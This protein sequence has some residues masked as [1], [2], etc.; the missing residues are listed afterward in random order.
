MK[1]KVKKIPKYNGGGTISPDVLDKASGLSG[2]RGSY[3]GYTD[4]VGAGLEGGMNLLNMAFSEQDVNVGTA[5]QGGMQGFSTGMQFGGPLGGVIGA[6]VG[7]LAGTAGRTNQVDTQSNSLDINQI[8][9]EGSGWLQGFGMSD[10]EMDVLANQVQRSNMAKLQ[11]ENLKANYYSNPNVVQNPN[12]LA[13]EGGVVPGEH[14]ASR[15]EVEVAADGT[16]AVKYGWDPK[17]KDTYHVYANPDGSS[18]EGN[19]VFTEEGVRR[20][21][22]EKYSDA[23]EKII[24][25]TKEGSKLRQISLRKLANEMEVQ[26]MCKQIKKM[27]NGVP[28]HEGGTDGKRFDF[29]NSFL[30]R[31]SDGKF[32]MQDINGNRQDVPEMMLPYIQGDEHGYW[33]GHMTGV[34]PS[35]GKWNGSM[36]FAKQMLNLKNVQKLK[37]IATRVFGRNAK[38]VK[39]ASVKPTS[40][41]SKPLEDSAKKL[42]EA[43]EETRIAQEQNRA[44]MS[45][46]WL[47]GRTPQNNL[48]N[49]TIGRDVTSQ[50]LWN[51]PNASSA[52]DDVFVGEMVRSDLPYYLGLASMIGGAGVFLTH[53]ATKDKKGSAVSMTPVSTPDAPIA[54]TTAKTSDTVTDVPAASEKKEEATT[55]TDPKKGTV[56]KPGSNKSTSS[57]KST[58]KPIEINQ[59]GLDWARQEANRVMAQYKP[60]TTRAIAPGLSSPKIDPTEIVEEAALPGTSVTGTTGSNWRD[61][62]YR[63]AVLSQPLWD[64]AKAEPVDWTA[65]IYKYM[66]TQ[67]DVT[68]QFRDADQSYALSRYNFANL[69]PNTGAGMAA[70]LQA[71]SNRAKQ[72]ADIRQYQTNAQN[73]L[74]GKNVG[75]Y[76]NWANEHARILNDVYNRNAANRAAARNINRQNRSAALSN[77]GQMLRDDKQMAMERMKFAALK[78]AISATYEDATANDILNMYNSLFS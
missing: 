5:L 28:A 65:P 52:V 77:Y 33:F 7:I 54:E 76:N 2:S 20:P 37:N 29:D 47:R 4:K 24:K 25:G 55:V 50:G 58:E 70:G 8:K 30:Y 38:P 61:G 16:N 12:V 73:E 69:Y 60:N 71:A 39:P 43:L 17:G 49:A 22:G 72:Y 44:M 27:K 46:A 57:A 6:G 74:I 23:A 21:N 9:K 19:M 75:I 51:L 36:N 14:Y 62:L 15:G 53:E 1:K 66:P 11:T 31:Q 13:A 3:S 48:A 34:A 18:T 56:A 26:K 63:M 40:S 68:S 10:G 41:N 67:I 35:A 42:G 45:Q 78:P 64:R 59:A 32:V